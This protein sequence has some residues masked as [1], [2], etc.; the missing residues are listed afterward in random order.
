MRED[1][2]NDLYEQWVS[3]RRL[4]DMQQETARLR[5]AYKRALTIAYIEFVVLLIAIVAVA[6]L[7]RHV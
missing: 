1:I 7:L 2:S 5:K 3:S 4:H 6:Y